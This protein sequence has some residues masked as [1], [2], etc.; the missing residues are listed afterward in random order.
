[1][2]VLDRL[3]SV[4][5]LVVLQTSTPE[6]ADIL[7][8]KGEDW[9]AVKKV[10]LVSCMPEG[11]KEY[12]QKG[13][14]HQSSEK[15]KRKSRKSRKSTEKKK[16]GEGSDSDADKP[17]KPKAS[18]KSGSMASDNVSRAWLLACH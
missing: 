6:F 7:Q 4:Q 10:S 14:K 8:Y 13:K 5:D 11:I 1:M 16:K 12:Y 2:G 17:Q 15:S 3:L 18:M 9:Q